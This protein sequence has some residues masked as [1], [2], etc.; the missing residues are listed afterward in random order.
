[1]D[2]GACY[3]KVLSA[4]EICGSEGHLWA[5]LKCLEIELIETINLKF[6]RNSRKYYNYMLFDSQR[7]FK[8]FSMIR[9]S[10]HG[11][12]DDEMYEF[13]SGCFYL[14]KGQADRANMHLKEATKDDSC[15]EKLETIRKIWDMGGGVL[16]FKFFHNASSYVASTREAILIDFI[17]LKNLTNNRR[18]SYYG[19]VDL[20]GKNVLVNLGKYLVAGMING[21]CEQHFEI[22]LREDILRDT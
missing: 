18:G 1:M 6:K 22:I 15:N 2:Y 5:A 13:L 7:F 3:D 21:C 16:I 4:Q 12:T 20:W 14:G 11:I 8:T 9:N 17:G 19:G 10:N